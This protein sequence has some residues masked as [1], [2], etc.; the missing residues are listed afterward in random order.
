MRHTAF[1]PSFADHSDKRAE[2]R[3][4]ACKRNTKKGGGGIPTADQ[5]VARRDTKPLRHTA[6]APSFADHSNK[7]AEPRGSAC[8]RKTKM[9]PAGIEPRTTRLPGE[10]LN[11]CATRLLCHQC[12]SHSFTNARLA[13]PR[14]RAAPTGMPVE[15][16]SLASVKFFYFFY[17]ARKPTQLACQ[18]R[19]PLCALAQKGTPRITEEKKKTADEI[20]TTNRQ[21]L[22]RAARPLRHGLTST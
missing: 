22:S 15:R 3:G 21:S 11:R 20:R 12:S 7:R 18:L 10:T 8:K 1:A 4:S 13:A 17:R 14:N 19:R 2:P 5:R 9:P 16:N 6:V